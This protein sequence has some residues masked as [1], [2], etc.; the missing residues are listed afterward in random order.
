MPAERNGP[1]G[2]QNIAIQKARYEGPFR[3][4]RKAPIEIMDAISVDDVRGAIDSILASTDVKL[5]TY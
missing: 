2:S 4:R 1:Y 5:A 3:L